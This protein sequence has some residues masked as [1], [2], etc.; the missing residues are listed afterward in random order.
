NIERIVLAIQRDVEGK[1]YREHLTN[2]QQ[3][4]EGVRGG[5]TEHLPETI[6]HMIST[7]APKMGM[8]IFVVIA[9]QVM[10]AGAYVIYKRRRAN[11][12]KKYL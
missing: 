7:A 6:S 5:L 10:L 9:F 2:L 3:S 12:P 1:D 8:F 4:I 11:A